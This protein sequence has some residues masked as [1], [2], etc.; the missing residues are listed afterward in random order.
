[1]IILAAGVGNL[2]GH[3]YPPY[4]VIDFIN[5]KGSYELL[6]IGVFNI[7]DFAFDVGIVGLIISIAFV[8][9]KRVFK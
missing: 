4:R 8:V 1:L 5:I 3:F 9:F 2:I 6:R 7:A